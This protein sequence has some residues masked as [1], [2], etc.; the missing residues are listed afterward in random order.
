LWISTIFDFFL[1]KAIDSHDEPG[2]R[3][4][5]LV[6]SLVINLGFLG[7]FKYGNFITENFAALM[8]LLNISYSP[9]EFDILLPVGISFYT[10]VTLSYTIDVYN[11]KMKAWNSMLDYALFV[12]FFPHLV[13][14][15]IVRARDFLPQLENPRK[16]S[17]NELGW[18]LILIVIGLFNKM[19]IADTLM[20]PVA[21]QIFDGVGIPGFFQA[22]IGTLAFAIQIFCDFSGY[23]MV[24]IGAALALGFVFPDNFRYPYGSIGFSDFWRRWHITL[25][26]WL[27]DYLYIPLGGNKKGTI[28]T[29]INLMLTML[30]GGLWHGASWLFVIWGGLHGFYL[31]LER[32]LKSSPLANWKI[33]KY[34]I[35]QIGL[36]LVTFVMVC[37]AWVFF[38]AGS[39]DRA[40]L[41]TNAMLGSYSFST[42]SE[43]LLPIPEMV[44]VLVVTGFYLIYQYLMRNLEFETFSLRIPWW[45]RSVVLAL[46]IILILNTFSGE[47]RAFIYF[48]F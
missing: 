48:Q 10:F 27:R 11:R 35:I 25:S 17:E 39:L 31:I 26:S 13:A 9:P 45:V 23:S 4:F 18:G 32:L 15:P 43:I 28:R 42:Y 20:A 21:Q 14:G 33:W 29:Y 41:I 5:W 19:V 30:I 3:K 2:R 22:W 37:F 46:L 6:M 24:A 12:T 44:M 34:P 7:F 47:D 40:L 38:R 36:S 1:A 16:A 8:Q